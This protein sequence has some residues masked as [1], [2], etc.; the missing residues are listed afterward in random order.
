MFQSFLEW[1]IK[2]KW[3]VGVGRDLGGIEDEEENRGA[4]YSM[5]KIHMVRNLNRIF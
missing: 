1:R 3:D 4:G 2:Y 5:N